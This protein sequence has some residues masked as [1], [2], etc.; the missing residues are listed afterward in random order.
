MFVRRVSSLSLLVIGLSSAHADTLHVA[1]GGD[2]DGPGSAARPW[3]TLQHAAEQVHAGDV[4]EVAAGSYR[5]F[6]LHRAGTA[7]APIRFRAAPGAVI[8]SDNADTPDG[9]SLERAAHVVI[10]GFTI[11]GASRFGIRVQGAAEVALFRNRVEGAGV[12]GIA[13]E[14]ADD[15][16]I[17]DNVVAG[18]QRAHGLDLAGGDRPRVIGNQVSDAARDGV[19]VDGAIKRGGDGVVRGARIEE[20]TVWGN[21]A[22]GV[23]LDGAADAVVATNVVWANRGAAVAAIREDGGAAS[24]GLR[25]VGNTLVAPEGAWALRLRERAVNAVLGNDLLLSLD[26]AR[27]AIDASIDSLLGLA[28]DHNLVT[29]RFTLDGGATT[30]DLA[31][32]RIRTKADLGSQAAVAEAVFVDVGRAEFALRPGSPAID[33]GDDRLATA[34]D[35]RR[36]TRVVGAHVDVGAL[37]ACRGACQPVAGGSPAVIGGGGGCGGKGRG[38]AAPALLVAWALRRRRVR[39]AR[40]A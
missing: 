3:R 2:D 12:S 5:G 4:V 17:E 26:P 16:V 33:R 20:N 27:G 28:S 14:F 39:P 23:L 32:W 11:R 13:A 38:A 21:G 10:E 29:P 34:R 7:D 24:S 37:E 1:G 8:T 31:G 40:A 25:L 19:H 18:A 22:A 15:L 9:I 35:A 36:M 6:A 30:V